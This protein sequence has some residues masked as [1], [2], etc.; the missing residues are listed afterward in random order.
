MQRQMKKKT[1]FTDLMIKFCGTAFISGNNF[2]KL[3]QN[4][5]SKARVPITARYATPI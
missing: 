2:T 4:L 3:G 1:Q 5:S